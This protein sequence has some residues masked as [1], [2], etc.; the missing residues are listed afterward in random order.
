[1]IGCSSEAKCRAYK[2]IVR[3]IMEYACAIWSPHT[4]KDINLL[5]AVQ[6]WALYWACG[7]RWDPSALSWT[8]PHNDCYKQLNVSFV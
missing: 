7:S 8:I 4:T 1:M 5:E 3:H 2:A 6:K